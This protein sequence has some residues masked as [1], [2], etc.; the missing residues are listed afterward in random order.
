VAER[1]KHPAGSSIDRDGPVSTLAMLI[2]ISVL[3]LLI[4]G[5][6]WVLA[7]SSSSVED[8]AVRLSLLLILGFVI[9]IAALTIVVLVFGRLGLATGNYAVGLP[10]GSIRAFLALSLVLLFF[11]LAV[12]LFGRL[13]STEIRD[14]RGLTEAERNRLSGQVLS[15]EPRANT[16]PPVFDGQVLIQRSE[17]SKDLA[18]Q[19]LATASTLVVA[20][21]AFY[22]GA[23][24][25]SQAWRRASNGGTGEP[26]D[27]QIV[28]P[29]GGQT[30]LLRNPDG[31][32]RDLPITVKATPASEE[33]RGVVVDPEVA[34]TLEPTS[35]TGGSFVFKPATDVSPSVTRIRF[36]LVNTPD[37]EAVLQVTIPPPDKTTTEKQP[38]PPPE[39]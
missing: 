11:I 30:T 25:V 14:F 26:P 37:K 27:L 32:L 20:I 19:L 13:S 21:A 6:V 16:T 28:S 17:E 2:T 8:D 31:T 18:Q 3:V 1:L 5:A 35:S 4:V 15:A 12:N 29:P 34:G 10:E 7:N 24:S 9:F 36:W 23:Q 33:V 38:P 39:R 22:F